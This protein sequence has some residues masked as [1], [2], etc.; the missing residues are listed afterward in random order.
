MGHKKI[1][2]KFVSFT[3]IS[4]FLCSCQ[5]KESSDS[6]LK[7]PEVEG[8]FEISVLKIGQADSIILKTQN[9][10]VVID[11]GEE[12]DGSEVVEHLLEKG[13]EKIDYLLITHFD[14][15]HVGGASEVIENFK[16][17]KIIMPNYNSTIDEYVKFENTMKE[18]NI[19]PSLLTNEL[20]FTLDDVLFKV[21]PPLKNS[22]KEPDNDFSLV[23]SVT[24]GENKFLFAGDAENDRLQELSNQL[25][26]DHDFLKMPHHGKFNKGTLSFLKN[27]TPTYTVITDSEKNPAENDTIEALKAVKSKVFQTKN[28]NVNVLSDG[29]SISVTQ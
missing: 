21:Y 23:I 1:F 27:V 14:K 22:Y 4:V 18:Q 20:S 26:L 25:D 28:G 7:P 3:L 15:D 13:T 11:C 16:A 19:T 17:D 29:Y 6:A 12:D 2:I 5:F 24:H 10:T 8:N 9:H